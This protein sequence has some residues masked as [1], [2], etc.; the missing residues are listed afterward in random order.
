MDKKPFTVNT[1]ERILEASLT[2]FAKKGYRATTVRDIAREI[3]ITQGALYNHFKNKDAILQTLLETLT[4]SVIV[5]IFENRD[6]AEIYKKGKALLM[7]ISST[8]KLAGFDRRNEMLFKLLMQ[9][10]FRNELVRELYYEHFYQKNVKKLSTIFF[11]MMQDEMIKSM[12]PL[13]LANE[14]F[15]SLFFYQTQILLLKIDGK[16]TSA[17]SILFEKHTDMFWENIR[18]EKDTYE[19]FG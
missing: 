11:Y 13:M 18:L 10:L 2:L 17:A 8:F 4:D 3:G 9:E 19:R 1:R 7:S 16:S 12:D 6:P 15:S 14:F 5:Q